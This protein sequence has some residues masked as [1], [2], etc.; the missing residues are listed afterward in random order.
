MRGNKLK[1]KRL[2]QKHCH[3]FKTFLGSKGCSGLPGRNKRQDSKKQR[4]KKSK[5][6]QNLKIKIKERYDMINKT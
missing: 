5:P 3:K 2:T 1:T 6:K 4:N